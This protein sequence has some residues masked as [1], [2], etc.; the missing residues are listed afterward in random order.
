MKKT[1]LTAQRNFANSA[2]NCYY[3]PLSPSFTRPTPNN[4]YAAV[5]QALFKSNMPSRKAILESINKPST[6]G[7]YSVIFQRLRFGGLISYN[8]KN[9]YSLTKLG[10]DYAREFKLNA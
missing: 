4:G 9:G 7:Y 3:P 8:R 10:R 5:I 6:P 2:R 1:Y